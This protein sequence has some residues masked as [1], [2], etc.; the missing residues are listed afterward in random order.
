M[1]ERT[2]SFSRMND[3][4]QLMKVA[5][6]RG[7]PIDIAL[8]LRKNLRSLQDVEK[9]AWWKSSTESNANFLQAKEFLK[10]ISAAGEKIEHAYI[11]LKM[12]TQEIDVLVEQTGEIDAEA[13]TLWKNWYSGSIV[14]LGS[15]PSFKDSPYGNS[16]YLNVF[17]ERLSFRL[18]SIRKFMAEIRAYNAIIREIRHYCDKNS[19]STRY[20]VPQLK[21][22]P[23]YW[24]PP[25]EISLLKAE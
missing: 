8:V 2:Y 17:R 24:H 21:G 14:Y 6:E 1:S 20:G 9:P 4:G 23:K 11:E 5:S 3:S 12:I 15:P 16:Q 18:E 13:R 25:E 7:H 19:S 22:F 10:V